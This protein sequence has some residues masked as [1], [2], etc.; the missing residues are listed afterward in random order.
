MVKPF[1]S[2]DIFLAKQLN[3]LHS[4]IL[5]DANLKVLLN[6]HLVNMRLLLDWKWL[7]SPSLLKFSLLIY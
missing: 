5:L 4:D 2:T 7:E 1:N 6:L 3:V